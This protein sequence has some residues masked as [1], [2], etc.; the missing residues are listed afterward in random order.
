[1]IGWKRHKSIFARLTRTGSRFAAALGG[2]EAGMAQVSAL[3]L[4]A[5]VTAGAGGLAYSV[6]AQGDDATQR[7]EEVA[8]EA[9][10][11]SKAVIMIKGPIYVTDSDD[12]RLIDQADTISFDIG[13]PPGAQNSPLT[14]VQVSVVTSEGRYAG[15]ARHRVIAGDEDLILESGET[16]ELTVATPGEIHAG[17]RFTVHVAPAGGP[18]AMMSRVMPPVADALTTLY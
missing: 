11:A 3:V 15:T 8:M 12:N 1:M 4:L 18:T 6:A 5:A 10:D 13:L 14:E 16:I 17:D 2:S 9:V 7:F